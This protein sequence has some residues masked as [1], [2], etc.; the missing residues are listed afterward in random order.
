MRKPTYNK[1]LPFFWTRSVSWEG[2]IVG[3]LMH[4]DL[5][6]VSSVAVPEKTPT[7]W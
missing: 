2:D 4:Y 5:R 6:S 3:Y 7:W 1:S